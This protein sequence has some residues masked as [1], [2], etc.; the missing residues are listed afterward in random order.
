MNKIIMYL[1]AVVIA[2]VLLA[3]LLYYT[4]N[5]GVVRVRASTTTS[6]YATG[7][8]EYL[9]SK[10]QIEHSNVRIDYMPVGSG[11]ALRRA[12]DGEACLVLV[13][14]PSLEK[15][16]IEKGILYYH[17]IF[18]YN[19]FIIIGPPSD[20]AG[21][22]NSSSI[23]EVMRKIYNAGEK[24]LAK[25]L[26]RGDNSGTNVKEKELW[27]RAGLNPY[28]EK[29]YI[30]SGT[31]MGQ[32]LVMADQMG[33]YTISDKGTYLKYKAEGRIKNLVVLY[34]NDSALI[35]IYSAYLVKGCNGRELEAARSF[36]DFITSPR[37][38]ELI[39][40]YGVDTYG[41]PLFYPAI[42]N[43]GIRDAW[44]ELSSGA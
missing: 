11:E 19:Y 3:S 34:G 2:A 40:S 26:S 37:G 10:F 33:A 31:G 6:L 43:T 27:G 9:S 38:Q 1:A 44:I 13:H 28:S 39:G 29:W 35:N 17:H 42:N 16:Y 24:G 36:I 5:M 21:I 30:E 4:S 18:A 41:E 14:A 15:Q 22:S 12:G 7:L 25:F 20:P 32:T 23:E 8:L